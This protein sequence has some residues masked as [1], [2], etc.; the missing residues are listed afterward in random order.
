MKKE[1]KKEIVRKSPE[2]SKFHG[3]A[4][5]KIKN[6]RSHCIRPVKLTDLS[7]LF[8]SVFNINNGIL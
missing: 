7:S 4:K 8:F 6:M 5:I 1:K 2:G 3:I